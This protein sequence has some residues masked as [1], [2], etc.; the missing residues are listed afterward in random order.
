[1]ETCAGTQGFWS[2][3]A[4][5]SSVSPCSGFLWSVSGAFLCFFCEAEKSR[6]T[7]GFALK[8]LTP[9]DSAGEEH[10]I[11]VLPLSVIFALYLSIVTHRYY[12]LFVLCSDSLVLLGR[13]RVV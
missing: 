11:A 12:V 9:R 3:V 4:I 6:E 8:G 7:R 2:S 1:M 5:L 13:A 10:H